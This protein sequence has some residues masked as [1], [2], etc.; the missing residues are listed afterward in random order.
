MSKLVKCELCDADIEIQEDVVVGEVITCPECG[1]EYEVVKITEKGV[2]IKE[3]EKIEED[4][5]E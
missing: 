5:G 4:W 1:T 2:V 3:A